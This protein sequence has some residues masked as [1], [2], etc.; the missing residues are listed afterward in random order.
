[1]IKTYTYVNDIGVRKKLVVY[2]LKDGKHPVTL[3]GMDNGEFAGSGELTPQEL[4]DWLAHYNV[5]VDET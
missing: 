5:K 2:Q 3:W 1:M 4:K